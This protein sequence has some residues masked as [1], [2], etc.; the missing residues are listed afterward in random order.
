MNFQLCTYTHDI[1]HDRYS[2]F[3]I[4]LGEWSS[5]TITGTK[6]PPVFAF[7]FTKIDS[8]RAV[9]YG[10]CGSRGTCGDAYVFELDKWVCRQYNVLFFVKIFYAGIFQHMSLCYVLAVA[11]RTCIDTFPL[12]LGL[13]RVYIIFKRF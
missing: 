8:K 11:G 6:P 4:F 9:A 1:L 5:P 2:L 13:V 3:C 7:S 10:G 12:T